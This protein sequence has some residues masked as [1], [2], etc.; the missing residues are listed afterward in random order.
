MK[1]REFL[2]AGHTPTLLASLMYFDVSFMVWV[3]L[4]PLTP[5][6]SEQLQLNPAQKGLMTAIPLLGGSLFRP[7]LGILSDRILQSI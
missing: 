2:K 5:F 7:V 6:I 4:G 3:L 1:I